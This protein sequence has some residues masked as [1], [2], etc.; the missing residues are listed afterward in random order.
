MKANNI[1]YNAIIAWA[2]VAAVFVAIIALIFQTKSSRFA[3]GIDLIFKLNDYFDNEQMIK[4]RKEAAAAILNKTYSGVDVLLNF[5][6]TIGFLVKKNAIDRKVVWNF[7]SFFVINYY[8]A[9]SNFIKDIRKDDKTVWSNLEYLYN[10]LVK[11]EKS[12]RKCKDSDIIISPES[13]ENFLN[14]EASL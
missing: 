7:F 3:L 5:F 1:D 9:A 2:S 10:E 13:L 14:S 11:I 12:E 6:E 4:I 8:Q